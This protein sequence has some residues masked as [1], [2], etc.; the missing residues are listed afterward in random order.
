[1]FLLLLVTLVNLYY[2]PYLTDRDQP[3][4]WLMSHPIS[5]TACALQGFQCPS[6]E[7]CDCEKFCNNGSDYVPF[8]ILDE[9]DRV[10]VLNQKLSPGTYC[11]PKGI[12]KCNLKTSYHVFSL[13]GWSC[14]GI[15]DDIFK[16]NKKKACKNEEAQDNSLNILYDYQ[17]NERAADYIENYYEMFQ[18]KL[19]YGC[20][21]ESK[22][23]DNTRMISIFP[24][25]CLVDYCL[26]DISN[27]TPTMGWNGSECD[28]GPYVHADSNDKTSPCRTFATNMQKNVLKGRVDCMTKESFVRQPLI[29]PTD[30]GLLAFKEYFM[31]GNEPQKFVDMIVH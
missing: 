18:N 5:K 11:L 22:S 7:M 14:I 26:R 25:V 4:N 31:K 15:N 1:M 19:R 20:K 21:C 10:Y 13:A 29:C 9:N 17:K 24:F 8:K 27:P 3:L 23:L 28:C 2:K 16:K 12:G 6:D 30:N